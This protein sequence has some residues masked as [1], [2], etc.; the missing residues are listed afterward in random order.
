MAR[1]VTQ[2]RIVH[3]ANKRV[4][5]QPLCDDCCSRSLPA[6][7]QRHSLEPPHGQP[8]LK[9]AQYGALRI[10]CSM[11]S[12]LLAIDTFMGLVLCLRSS[13]MCH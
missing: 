4:L 1:V 5:R 9:W 11:M 6:H 8:A 2:P 3:F 13:G 12:S 7:P 10:L